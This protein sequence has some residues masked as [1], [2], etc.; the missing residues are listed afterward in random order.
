MNL[1]GLRRIDPAARARALRAAVWV[2]AGL[3]LFNLLFGEMGVVAGLRQR[4]TAARLRRE[5]AELQAT[6][7]ALKAE[8]RAL[9]TDPFR[10]EAIAREQ[11]GLARPGEI[12]FLFPS[13]AGA[14]R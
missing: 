7:D 9:K 10:I 13:G 14:E 8:V 12:V 2:L 5:V 11:L 1:A 3:L 6:T 4:H